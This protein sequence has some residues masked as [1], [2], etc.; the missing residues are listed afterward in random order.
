[1]AA[2]TGKETLVGIKMA[3]TYGTAVAVD[4]L[5][6]CDSFSQSRNVEKLMRSPLGLNKL[7]D[8][9]I[10]QGR[11]TPSISGTTKIGFQNNVEY[12]I[13]QFFGK[14]TTPAEQTAGQ[15]DYLTRLTF[16]TVAPILNAKYLTVAMKDTSTTTLEFPAVAIDTLTI[17]IVPNNYISMDFNGLANDRELGSSTNTTAVLNALSAPTENEIVVRESD[18]FLINAQ[19][20]G[21]LTTVTDR[22]VIEQ[23]VITLTKPQE[24]IPLIKG[25]SGNGEPTSTGNYTCTLTVT[26]NTL[27]DH[28]WLTAAEA[29]TEYKAGFVFEGTQIGTGANQGFRLYFPRLQIVDD[30]EYTATTPGNNKHIVTYTAMQATA[31]PTGMDDKNPYIEYTNGIST[32]YI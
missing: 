4:K 28:T 13:A 12:L 24:S 10:T 14:S 2:I 17:T 20:G 11:A 23:A 5:I 8:T 16:N 21:A 22:K 15:S 27:E 1:M 3:T 32:A 29:G 18:E 26:Y 7:F 30:P 25:S 31:N 6:A 9:N 19:A